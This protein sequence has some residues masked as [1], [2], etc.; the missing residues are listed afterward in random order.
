MPLYGAHGLPL[1]VPPTPNEF[2]ERRVNAELQAHYDPLLSIRWYPTVFFNQRQKQWE[3]RYALVVRWPQIDKRWGTVPLGYEE[4]YDILGWFCED[5]QDANTTPADPVSI[6]GKVTELL[7]KCDNTRQPWMARMKATVEHNL[8]QHEKVKE[9]AL[10]QVAD[11]AA[12]QYYSS[13]RASRVF[14]GGKGSDG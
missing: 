2:T 14:M 12:S 3:G 1:Y 5:M 9:E 6:M 7:G 11:E 10:D 8:R 4:P 13:S